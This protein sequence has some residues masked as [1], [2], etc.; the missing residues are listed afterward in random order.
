MVSTRV[1]SG[2]Y[3]PTTLVSMIDDN[4]NVM[5]WFA[6]GSKDFKAGQKYRLKGTIKGHDNYQGVDQTIL[7]RAKLETDD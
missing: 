6:S 4:G 3:G 1:L 7:T 2:D 5:K